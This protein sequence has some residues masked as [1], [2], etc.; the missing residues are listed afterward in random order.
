MPA[1]AAD[2]PQA[3]QRIRNRQVRQRRA[4]IVIHQETVGQHVALRHIP[5]AV[6]I[7]RQGTRLGQVHRYESVCIRAGHRLSGIKVDRRR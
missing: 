1:R 6:V 4:A 2:R 7:G 3:R 5:G